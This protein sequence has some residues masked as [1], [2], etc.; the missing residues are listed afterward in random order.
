MTIGSRSV[1]DFFFETPDVELAR[2]QLPG[3]EV[4]I[5]YLLRREAQDCLFGSVRAESR[6]W[7]RR[8]RHRVFA[9]AMVL[10][11]GIDLLSK[12][13]PVPQQ[14]V[15]SRFK[16]FAERYLQLAPAEAEALYR[17]RN[18]LMH[19][20]GLYDPSGRVAVA[21]L[22][23]RPH[24]GEKPVVHLNGRWVLLVEVLLA[25]FLAGVRA[26]EAEVRA[27]R[28]LSQFQAAF[29]KYG[30]TEFGRVTS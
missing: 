3:G 4:S 23:R 2:H 5:L 7:R 1:V 21:V 22:N 16:G 17:V 10:M 6:L 29:A 28:G 20:F 12:F 18:T 19:S 26:Y 15:T 13:A 8:A 9:A 30:A 25:H 11:A 14:S 27:N 24:P